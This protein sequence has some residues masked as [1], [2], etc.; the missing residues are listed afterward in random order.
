MSKQHTKPCG[1]C[2]FRRNTAAGYLGADSPVHF[3]ATTLADTR[4][5]C[6]MKVDYEAPDWELQALKAPVCA[7]AGIFFANK[8]KMSRD[9]NRPRFKADHKLVFSNEREFLEHHQVPEANPEPE[10]S[11]D[12]S[13]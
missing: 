11:D 4:M 2:P 5:P 10:G 6:H 13:Y 9:P 8:C 3:I 12:D 1:E 7:G